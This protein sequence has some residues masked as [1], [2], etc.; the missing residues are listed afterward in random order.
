MVW[1]RPF[2]IFQ[3]D[4]SNCLAK[5]LKI[6]HCKHGLKSAHR[7]PTEQITS[8]SHPIP[9]SQSP[10]PL[11]SH[12]IHP[13]NWLGGW[14]PPFHRGACGALLGLI[15]PPLIF[16]IFDASPCPALRPAHLPGSLVQWWPILVTICIQIGPRALLPH[17]PQIPYTF[18]KC[19]PLR[20]NWV[21][22]I[23][24]N[25]CSLQCC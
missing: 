3:R 11:C 4:V 24:N 21:S 15:F 9:S 18:W 8:E 2:L 10:P 16:Y 23:I 7:A 1:K 22:K 25:F 20:R 5:C 13:D 6:V 17:P 19:F 14:W 12:T